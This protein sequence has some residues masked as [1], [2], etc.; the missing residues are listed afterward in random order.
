MGSSTIPAS[1]GGGL[2]P[3]Y[4]KYTSSGTFTLPDGYGPANPLVVTV[5]CIGGGGG[6]SATRINA[7]SANRFGGRDFSGYNGWGNVKPQRNNLTGSSIAAPL[8]QG[9]AGSGGI[10]QSV[11]SLTGNL[12]FTVGA[13]GAQNINEV[14]GDGPSAN[15][16]LSGRADATQTLTVISGVTGGT[17][18]T[19]TAGVL[20]AS[21]GAGQVT[22]LQMTFNGG[23]GNNTD[24]QF[25][26]LAIASG[27][28]GSSGAGGTPAGTAGQATPLLGAIAGGSQNT[29]PI[30]GA[31]GVG[32]KSDDLGTAT[33][34]EGTGGGHASIGASG[35]I[36]ITY[37][38]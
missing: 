15:S 6:G 24:P 4:V 28:F 37:W 35:A 14:S 16:V 23:G 32:G 9:A 7:A 8:T 19:S 31:S 22:G 12:V 3:K 34:A 27:G 30:N 38:A 11:L 13:A 25:N 10:A 26:N 18:G 21:G 2:R 5:Q 20:K 1:G 36:I 17:G 29:T 33:G